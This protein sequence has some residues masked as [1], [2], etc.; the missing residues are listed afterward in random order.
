ML[1]EINCNLCGANNTKHLYHGYDLWDTRS[2]SE[3]EVFVVVQCKNCGL[4][5]INPRVHPNDIAEYYREDYISHRGSIVTPKIPEAENLP[6]RLRRELFEYTRGQSEIPLHKKLLLFLFSRTIWAKYAPFHFKSQ[7]LKLLDIGCGIGNFL[8][9]QKSLGWNTWGVEPGE[10]AAQICVERGLDVK[11]GYFNKSDWDQD[12]FDVVTLHQVLEHVPYPQ[13][14]LYDVYEVLKPNGLIQIDVPNF[15]SVPAH[16][17]RQFWIGN[18]IP[19]HY[20]VYSPSTLTRLLQNAGFEV[21]RWY[22]CSSTSGFTG[23]IE[24][25]LREKLGFH[26]ERDAVRKN[27]MLCRLFQPPVRLLDLFDIGDNLYVIAR[28]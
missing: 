20:F 10:R 8:T 3:K 22:T 7:G 17:F 4:V 23:G 16:L 28:K 2:S 13:E 1:Q 25:V 19:R 21:K 18:D 15:R 5:Y 14:L 24:F 26:I 9:V 11:Q 12:V 27:R 6:S